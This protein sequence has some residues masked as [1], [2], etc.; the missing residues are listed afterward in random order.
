MHHPVLQE[1]ARGLLLGRFQPVSLRYRIH[2]RSDQ[3]IVTVWTG[4]SDERGR[5]NLPIDLAC[6]DLPPPYEGYLFSIIWEAVTP[7]GVTPLLRSNYEALGLRGNP[8]YAE[9]VPPN[10]SEWKGIGADQWIDRG[11]SQ[12]PPVSAGLLVQLI[13]VKGAGKSSHLAHWRSQR[14]GPAHYYPDRGVARFRLPPLASICYWDEACRIPRV[15][16]HWAL[17]WAARRGMTVCVG[18]HRDLSRE[19][20]LYGLQVETIA[21]DGIHPVEVQDW[22]AR[23]VASVAL[24]SGT[25]FSVPEELISQLLAEC[26]NSWRELGLR[27]HVWAAGEAR[28]AM[29]HEIMKETSNGTYK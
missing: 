15:W 2:G 4:F 17:F 22:A 12:P 27:L 21:L 28:E 26:G 20:R 7:E 1:A 14:P 8:F 13:G 11:H 29:Q 10:Q 5:V 3:T 24:P 16:L 6:D 19:A 9:D 23:R 18:T 25:D